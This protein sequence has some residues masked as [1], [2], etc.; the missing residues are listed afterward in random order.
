MNNLRT[1][2]LYN[3]MTHKVEPIVPIV[4]G[5]LSIYTCGPTVYS[6]AHIGNLK[7]YL[8]QDLMKRVF[9]ASGYQVNHCMNVTDVE[10]KIIRNSQKDLSL[11]ASNIERHKAMHAFTKPYTAA[12]WE[13]LNDLNILLPT[14]TP[15][16]TDYIKNVIKLVQKLESMN[17]AYVRNNSVYYRVSNL[18][19]Y[20]CLAKLDKRDTSNSTV[21]DID[22]Y[23]RDSVHDFALWKATKPGEPWWDSPWGP[24]RPGWHI[25]CSAMG[26]EL[27]G[28]YIDIHSGGIDLIF[29]HHENEIAQS[30]GYLGH[31]WVNTWVHGEFLLVNGEKMSKSLGNFYTI[32]DLK[33]KGIDPK[34]FRFN[35]QSNSYRKMLNFS[36]D[37]LNASANA[38]KRIQTF[39]KRMEKIEP[40]DKQRSLSIDIHKRI[41]EARQIFW[42]ALSDDL[43]TPEALA[44]IFTV[45]TDINTQ[46]DQTTFNR[47]EQ[48]AVLKFLD[49]T[50]AI[51]ACW[52]HEEV[53]IDSKIIELIEQRNVAKAARNWIEA[54]KL[55]DQLKAIGILLEDHKDGTVT[56]HLK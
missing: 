25:E 47:K 1:I 49:E 36:L 50:N 8:F 56:W 10:D 12:F 26:I 51:F 14:Y 34:V 32:R 33:A 52:P 24:G 11:D 48:V 43:N 31:K 7:T 20:G 30:E 29:P 35:I 19:S 40:S 41:D 15:K 9:L 46:C 45:I 37:S 6:F 4:P 55:R 3:T 17:L 13:D 16:A 5:V 44:A 42:T 22:E 28:E 23:G 18:S 38:L 21:T 53:E 2:H 27:L 39:R 54:D